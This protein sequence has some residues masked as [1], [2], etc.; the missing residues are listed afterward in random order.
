MQR[1]S[2]EH[3]QINV[4]S[5]IISNKPYQKFQLLNPPQ[6]Q[7]PKLHV[8]PTL[9]GLACQVSLMTTKGLG[10]C[11]GCAAERGHRGP[12]FE[13]FHCLNVR[14]VGGLEFGSGMLKKAKPTAT[15]I[16]ILL[17]FLGSGMSNDVECRRYVNA[18]LCVHLYAHVCVRR[19]MYA[20]LM[21]MYAYVRI[22]VYMYACHAYVCI[23]MYV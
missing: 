2:M 11:A 7:A 4:S 14:T 1:F 20:F 22:C 12:G 5:A 10:D 6:K 15:F 19:H 8:Q 13:R 9:G 23:C 17:L 21:H 16:Y 3:V 18:C